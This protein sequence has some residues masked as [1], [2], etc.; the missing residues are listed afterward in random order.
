MKNKIFP[1]DLIAV[2]TEKDAINQIVEKSRVT[3]TVFAE[4]GSVSRTE[5]M[6]GG[7][8][9]LTPSLKVTIYDFEYDGEEIVRYAGRL[10]SVYRTFLVENSDRIELYLETKGGTKNEPDSNDSAS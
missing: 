6:D 2:T 10:Y 3:K 4:V 5:F 9:G 8:I 1:I 7:R